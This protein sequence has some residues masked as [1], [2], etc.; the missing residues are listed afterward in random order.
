M[1]AKVAKERKATQ[2]AKL[3][4]EE[5]VNPEELETNV[6]AAQAQQERIVNR[7][8]MTVRD[9]GKQG[10][11]AWRL[12]FNAASFAQTVENTFYLS[13]LVKKGAVALARGPEGKGVSVVAAEG[14]GASGGADLD[15]FVVHLDY[16]TWAS[17]RAKMPGEPMMKHR[18]DVED[19]EARAPRVLRCCVAKPGSLRVRIPGSPGRP[20]WAPPQC[21]SRCRS[22]GVA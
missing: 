8:F 18:D 17:L 19:A 16:A 13:F 15:Q 11:D 14:G 9:R 20:A 10:V 22:T 2:R 6:N 4:M 12:V 3:V 7:M 5:V 1:E 21:R